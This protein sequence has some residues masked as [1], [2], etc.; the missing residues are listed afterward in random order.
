MARPGQDVT[1]LFLYRHW[2]LG[3][4]VN[5]LIMAVSMMLVFSVF[6]IAAGASAAY[7]LVCGTGAGVLFG[8]AVAVYIRSKCGTRRPSSGTLGGSPPAGSEQ[9]P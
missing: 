1:G 9:R 2:V 7:A 4:L 3:G 6:T 5:G 8:I